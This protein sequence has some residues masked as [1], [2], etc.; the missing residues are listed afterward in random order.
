MLEL[1]S[2]TRLCLLSLGFIALL[3]DEAKATGLFMLM[4]GFKDKMQTQKPSIWGVS[5]VVVPVHIYRDLFQ[6][7]RGSKPLSLLRS[8]TVDQ[9]L[10]LFPGLC[11]HHCFRDQRSQGWWSCPFHIFQFLSCVRGS[12]QSVNKF[13]IFYPSS[14]NIKPVY[15]IDPWHI[16]WN[17]S[18]LYFLQF[19]WFW[20]TKNKKLQTH[21]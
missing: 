9:T 17:V 2:V 13:N 16:E 3:C 19:L 20:F 6:N 10:F 8:T 14:N 7:L 15:Y 1:D 12:S 4:L 21:Q 18:S 5:V 11:S